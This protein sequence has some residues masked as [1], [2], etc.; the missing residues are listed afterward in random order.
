MQSCNQD[1]QG[2]NFT[3]TKSNFESSYLKFFDSNSDFRTSK[4]TTLTSAHLKNDSE[5]ILKFATPTT[6]I[7]M[8]L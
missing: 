2:K 4:K 1:S 3:D 7:L 6:P 5:F 8:I